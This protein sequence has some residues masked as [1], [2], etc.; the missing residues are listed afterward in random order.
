MFYFV[1]YFRLKAFGLFSTIQSIFGL[2]KK[3]G[4]VQTILEP[5]E[6]HGI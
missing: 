1:Q 2:I 3:F 5:V 6:G 4:P